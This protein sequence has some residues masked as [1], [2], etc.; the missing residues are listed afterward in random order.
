[1]ETNHITDRNKIMK[2]KKVTKEYYELEDGR[3]FYFDEPLDKVPSV[4]EMQEM[5]DKNKSIVEEIK[6]EHS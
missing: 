4:K 1:M 3:I 2:V 5:L 6:G